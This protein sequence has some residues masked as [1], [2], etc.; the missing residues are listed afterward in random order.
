MYINFDFVYRPKVRAKYRYGRK[1]ARATA[2]H[3]F[4][5]QSKKSPQRPREDS[6]LK[7]GYV[8]C[9]C[10][11]GFYTEVGVHWDSPPPPRIP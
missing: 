11:C 10:T 2:R 8:N 4:T 6:D 9:M 3:L 1:G 7:P 5:P